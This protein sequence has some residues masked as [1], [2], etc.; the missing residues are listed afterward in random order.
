ML[1]AVCAITAATFSKS[2]LRTPPIKVDMRPAAADPSGSRGSRASCSPPFVRSI[3]PDT[4]ATKRRTNQLRR[5]RCVHPRTIRRAR[6]GYRT[7]CVSNPRT[8]NPAPAPRWPACPAC[9]SAGEASRG[10]VCCKIRS[11]VARLCAQGFGRGRQSS[12]TVVGPQGRPNR[13]TWQGR[14]RRSP[15][16]P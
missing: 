6:G 12:M 4:A 16:R 13:G 7:F 10:G 11:P 2:R 5:S 1:S 9:G 8:R 3:S 15:R 14:C